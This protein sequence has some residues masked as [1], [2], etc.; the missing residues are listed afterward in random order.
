LINNLSELDEVMTRPS[1][2]LVEYMGTFSGRLVVLGAGGKMGPSLCIRAAR[3]I[4]AGAADLELVAVSRF[5][6]ESAR[7]SVEC[8]GVATISSNLSDC[9]EVSALP[10]ADYVIYLVGWKFGTSSSPGRT[11]AVNTVVPTT[12]MQRYPGIP[13]V[14][15]SSGNVYPFVPADCGGAAEN[16]APEPIGEYAWSVLGRERVFEHWSEEFST[17]TVLMRL[18]YAVD[19]RYGVLVDLASTI[20]AGQPVDLTMGYL[21]CIWQGDANELIIRSLRLAE[22]PA[23]PLNVTGTETLSVRA[24][25]EMLAE[26][27]NVPVTFVGQESPT[28][29]LNDS[30]L[31][32]RLLGTPEIPIERVVQWTA[33]WIQNDLP[34]LGKPTHF[35]VRDG[36]Y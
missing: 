12:V 34:V 27:M 8:R 22:Y 23:R 17:P 16:V 29:L 13:T 18:N 32:H 30:S 20:K 31:I 1:E 14:A 33:H 15:L 9:T 21:N 24:L 3:A 36:S 19:L 25:A 35:E 10:D 7:S 2:A 4:E 5:S 6:G 11:W 26:L 28:A